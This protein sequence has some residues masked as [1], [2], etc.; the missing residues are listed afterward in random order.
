MQISS[1]QR[2]TLVDFPGKISCVVFTPGCNFRCD[3]CHNP[4]LVLPEEI[5]KNKNFITEN[6]FFNFLSTRKNL[7]DGVVITGGEPTLQKDLFSFLQKIR[8][9]NFSIKLDTNGTN[10][11]ILEKIIYNNLVDYFAMDIKASPQN[12]EKICGT[13]INF[14]DIEKS[15][16]LIQN[17]SKN[18][19]FRTTVFFPFFNE[20][21]I[22][23]IG[24][25]IR[26][27]KKFFLQNFSN[28]GKILNPQKKFFGFPVQK[29]E[30]FKKIA[31]KFV[32][33]CEIR[34]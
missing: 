16:N 11:K 26:G 18:Y 25:F 27:S 22:K 13:K 28:I 15:K 29:L 10:P 20:K 34:N 23:E 12:Y 31:E 17:S 4:E 6:S 19:E 32:D 1:V 3:F 14:S 7:L 5:Q 9:Q 2:S 33:F 30:Q 21:E 8:E 24:K